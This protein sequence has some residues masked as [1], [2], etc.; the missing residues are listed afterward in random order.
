MSAVGRP[1]D[2]FSDTV[3]QLHPVFAQ[4]IQNTHYL[5]PS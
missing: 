1:Q 5:A 4:R 3:I 2:M